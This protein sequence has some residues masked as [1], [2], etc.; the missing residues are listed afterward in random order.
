VL[1]DG[2]V[3]TANHD[4]ETFEGGHLEM[5]AD[6]SRGRYWGFRHNFPCHRELPSHAGTEALRVLQ[7]MA[8]QNLTSPSEITQAPFTMPEIQQYVDFIKFSND[9]LLDGG[10]SIAKTI[11]ISNILAIFYLHRSKTFHAFED[12]RDETSS[13]HVHANPY[14]CWPTMSKMVLT[15][16]CCGMPPNYSRR[17]STSYNLYR[18]TLQRAQWQTFLDQVRKERAAANVVSGLLLASSVAFLAVPNMVDFA[19]FLIIVSIGLSLGC[20]VIGFNSEVDERLSELQLIGIRDSL[21]SDTAVASMARAMEQHY[22]VLLLSVLCFFLAVFAF[23]AYS[24]YASVFVLKSFTV[25]YLFFVMATSCLMIIM[26]VIVRW[27]R[28][29]WGSN[30]IPLGNDL[31]MT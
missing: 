13:V 25:R 19:Q 4:T 14:S 18:R 29:F 24:I 3:A 31:D 2:R 7:V 20:V 27:N 1:Q 26:G 8:V 28:G 5:N 30:P 12:D 17:F 11:I 15:M 22:T 23:T 16:A 6:E 21:E 10:V 9:P